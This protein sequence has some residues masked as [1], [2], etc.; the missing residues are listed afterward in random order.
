MNHHALTRIAASAVFSI[1][2]LTGSANAQQQEGFSATDVLAPEFQL[3]PFYEANLD[4]AGKL[5]GDVLKRE[6]I[7]APVG[8]VACRWRHGMPRRSSSGVNGPDTAR[9]S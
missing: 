2:A 3:T 8:A 6:S 7:P 1:V 4:F 9:T 5:P